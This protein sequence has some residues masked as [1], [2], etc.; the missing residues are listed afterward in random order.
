MVW[1]G[2]TSPII[3]GLG[4]SVL[5]PTTARP[6]SARS[7]VPVALGRVVASLFDPYPALRPEEYVSLQDYEIRRDFLSMLATSNQENRI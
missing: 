2:I 1:R 6:G 4:A 5:N 3:L 7:V